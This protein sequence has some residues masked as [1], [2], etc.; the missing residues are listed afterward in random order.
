MIVWREKFIATAIHFLVTLGLAAC[1][2]A[3]IFLVWFPDPFATM[4]GGTELFMLVVGC[5]VA[6]G[7]LIS[8]VIYNSRKSRRKL[9]ID[10][11]I[12]GI[13][14]IAALVY[15]VSIV[16]GTRP[17]YVAYSIDRLEVVTAREF[18]DAELAAVRKPEYATLPFTGP[19]LVAIEVPPTDRNEALFSGLN[20]N[21][22]YLRPKFFVRYEAQVES[23]RGHARPIALLMKRKP[24]SRSLL[25]AAMRDVEI[26]AERVRWL[27]VHHSKGF[28]TALIDIND[29]KPIAYMDL[30]PY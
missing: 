28:W 30:D 23:I 22:I 10:Y 12:V 18:T 24:A 3:L 17:A 5:D 20:G 26:P 1:A 7:P 29:G 4:I 2:A 13:V 14:Q 6:L 8:L 25:E 11:T 21:D 9:I 16:A 19:R 15:G 27:P